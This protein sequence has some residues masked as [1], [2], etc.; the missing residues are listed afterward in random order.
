MRKTKKAPRRDL[1]HRL[2]K[3][4]FVLVMSGVTGK[5]IVTNSRLPGVVETKVGFNSLYLD[6]RQ[7]GFAVYGKV[8]S[9]QFGLVGS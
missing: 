4:I 6:K 8:L 9:V 3:H 2:I 1:L 5:F 7:R